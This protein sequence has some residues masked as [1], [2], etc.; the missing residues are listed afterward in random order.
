[1]SGKSDSALREPN[2]QCTTIR[3]HLVTANAIMTISFHVCWS[4][5]PLKRTKHSH[6]F[7]PWECYH[8]P[9]SFPMTGI[10][11]DRTELLRKSGHR[12]W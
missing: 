5:R 2:S 7:R 10:N 12:R 8:S 6:R 9:E 1:M 4:I 3:L 11:E